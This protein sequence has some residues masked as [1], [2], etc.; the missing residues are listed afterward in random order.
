M[1]RLIGVVGSGKYVGYVRT[2]ELA[3]A[4]VTGVNQRFDDGIP[5]IV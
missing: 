5:I 4:I 3:N 1:L 2:E